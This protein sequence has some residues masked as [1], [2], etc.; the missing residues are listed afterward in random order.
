MVFENLLNPIFNPLLN[1][2]TLWALVILSFL[3]SLVITLITK[4]ATDQDLMKRLKEEMK[5]L[6]AEMK[7]LK[8]EPEKAMQIQKQ[9]MQTNMRYM[10][11]SFK[12]M[13]YTFI[14]IIIIFSW[15]TANLA[16]DSILPGQEFTT[17]VVFGDNA[18][19]TIELSVPEGVVIDGAAK[20]EVKDSVVKWVLSGKKGEYLLE[21]SFDGKKYKKEVLITE[22]NKYREPIKIIKGDI[23]KSIEIG[24]EKKKVL[25]LFGW[26]LGWL[27]S[28][29]I[30]SIVFS[31]LIR[32]V[33]KVY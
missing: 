15:M 21:Y 10:K 33:I 31:M 13:F 12:S 22:E 14:P 7:E 23:I 5:E 24:N 3:I 6:Q 9:V 26:K 4:Y 8:K 1:L 11:Q 29:I 16:Y 17:S 32:K 20:K 30:F 28:Y 25:N 27:G 2:P 18:E 19:G